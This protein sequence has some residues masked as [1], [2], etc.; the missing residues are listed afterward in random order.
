MAQESLRLLAHQ[1]PCDSRYF[2]TGRLQPLRLSA[3]G[4]IVLL[5]LAVGCTDDLLISLQ[6]GDDDPGHEVLV[7]LSI[8]VG[9]AVTLDAS[10]RS[11]SEDENPTR[12]EVLSRAAW[13]NCH[14]SASTEAALKMAS[15]GLISCF[16]AREP[17]R[18]RLPR[19]VYGR[20]RLMGRTVIR[21][22][23]EGWKVAASN[24]VNDLPITT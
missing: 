3:V 15:S 4:L 9:S 20:Y 21:P 5:V 19:P 23:P 17:I 16:T 12:G 8:E 6:G 10:T 11:D 18:L 7:Q 13:L 2:Q 1:I 14:L 24:N 22:C